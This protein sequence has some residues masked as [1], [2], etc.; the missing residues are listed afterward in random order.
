MSV[1]FQIADDVLDV[2]H[3]LEGG[4]EAFGKE[5]GNDVREGKKTLM[6]IHAAEHAPAESVA[7]LE[8]ILWKDDNTDEEIEEALDILVETGSVSYARERANDLAAS[9]RDHLAELDL[10]EEPKEQLAE[11]CQFVV[12]REA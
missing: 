5:F 8:D 6:V 1:A 12:E 3:S 10:R 11:F 7:R 4:D 2:E 9:A